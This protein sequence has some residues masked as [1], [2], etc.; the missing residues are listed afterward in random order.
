MKKSNL[1][2]WN[3]TVKYEFTVDGILNS[4]SFIHRVISPSMRSIINSTIP[5]KPGST[6]SLHGESIVT[7]TEITEIKLI[8][9]DL[10]SIEEKAPLYKC[11]LP[12]DLFNNTDFVSCC[13]N[14]INNSDEE[15]QKKKQKPAK[16]KTT[17]K[18]KKENVSEYDQFVDDMRI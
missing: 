8:M 2:L 1:K 13:G 11:Q 7:K 10:L 16:K 6:S 4:G 17:R 14:D 12:N 5:T 18:K 15:I 9:N 3:V